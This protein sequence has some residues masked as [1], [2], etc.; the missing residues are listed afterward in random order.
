[1][2]SEK[3]QHPTDDRSA[4]ATSDG[5][6]VSDSDDTLATEVVDLRKE[7]DEAR[8]RALRQQAEWENFRK[9]ARREL[10]DERRYADLRL[11]TDLLPVLDNIQRA[12]DAA[13]KN[14]EGGSLLEGFKLV[15]QQL[16]TVL[17][18]HNCTQ[19]EA[20][21]KTFDPHLHEAVSQMPAPGQTPGTVLH[22]VR[23]GF[24]L[25]D[26]VIRPAQVIIVAPPE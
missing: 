18:Q 3:H 19:I 4:S 25:H 8:D 20:Q 2:S 9:R 26:R 10:D 17:G 6:G 14:H 11:L 12:I 1:M 23:E 16:D 5:G 21:G 15:R 13:S 7:L 24:L 22:V